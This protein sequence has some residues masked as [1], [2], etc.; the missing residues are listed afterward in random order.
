MPLSRVEEELQHELQQLEAAGAS[1][2]GEPVFAGFRHGD[3]RRGPRWV[4][5]GHGER[6]F[7]RMN[8]NSYLGLSVREEL[9]R[10]AEAAA[11][12]Y[13]V[14]PGAV[15]F[16]SGTSVPHLRLEAAL[17]AFHGREACLLTGSAYTA[18]MGVIV[19]LTT[20]ETAIVSD[21]LNHNCIVNGVRLARPASRGV[22]PHLD[23]GALEAEI[24]AAA[25]RD[26]RRLLIV[27]DGVFSMRGD[28]A[29]LAKIRAL[30][31]ERDARFPEGALLL[32]DDSHGVG[33]YGPTGRG[34]EEAC[35]A[36]GAADVLV[37]TLG[38]AFGVN[39]GYVCSSA[40]IVRWLREKNPFVVYSNPIGA[41]E[42]A[43]ANMALRIVQ[44]VEGTQLLAH[45]WAMTGRF[46]DGLI[47]L[48]YETIKSPHPVVPL[49]VRDTGKTA[50]LVAHLFASNVLATGLCHPVVPRGQEL[51]RFQLS[52]D[53]TPG[54]VDA[55]LEALRAFPER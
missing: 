24:D 20:P 36:P 42:A 33:A 45:L 15:R 26:A 10:E 54:D 9:I 8:S 52:A 46:T 3:A 4:L 34:T 40:R 31:R 25:A 27:T 13:G 23:L 17:A 12:R 30:V 21:E 50:R 6:E 44:S 11:L 49:L 22:Y 18:M 41:P 53:H 29:P 55:V 14:G 35:D 51:I 37:G 43:A 19:A 28:H 39:G 5:E 48:G 1:K 7:L 32:V 16:I 38:K 2:A 47:A